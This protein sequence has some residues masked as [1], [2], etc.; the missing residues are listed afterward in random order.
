MIISPQKK[1]RLWKRPVFIG[2]N[3]LPPTKTFTNWLRSR[4]QAPHPNVGPYEKFQSET[5]R[6]QLWQTCRSSVPPSPFSSLCSSIRW[7]FSWWKNGTFPYDSR[8]GIKDHPRWRVKTGCPW[9]W[10]IFLLNTK[11]RIAVWI[12]KNHTSYGGHQV[13]KAALLYVMNHEN[14]RRSMRRDLIWYNHGAPN[15]PPLSRVW[16]AKRPL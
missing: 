3:L 9:C 8:P 4:T 12:P 1:S 5:S 13:T 6:P 2:Y 15:Y 10:W 7:I 14:T 16:T 11:N